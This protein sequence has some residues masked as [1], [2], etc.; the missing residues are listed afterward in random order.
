MC[1]RFRQLLQRHNLKIL[2]RAKPGHKVKVNLVQIAEGDTKLLLC[3]CC[4]F[5]EHR[6]ALCESFLKLSLPDRKALVWRKHFV[7]QLSWS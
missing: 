4:D 5:V 1:Y 3:F 6:I 2:L 7:F